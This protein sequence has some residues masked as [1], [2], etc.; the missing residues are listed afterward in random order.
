MVPPPSDAENYKLIFAMI[1]QISC[2]QLDWK[3]IGNELG[4]AGSSA[5][6]RWNNL[7]KRQMGKAAQLAAPKKKDATGTTAKKATRPGSKRKAAGMNNHDAEDG[8]EGDVENTNN[9]NGGRTEKKSKLESSEDYGYGNEGVHGQHQV[10]GQDGYEQMEDG[11]QADDGEGYED[12]QEQQYAQQGV[13]GED[14]NA[15]P[16]EFCQYYDGYPDA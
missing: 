16:E 6:V 15:V 11:G 4:I 12:A 8:N 7:Q 2:S 14:E 3:A 9:N 1:S 10:Y 13:G 5:R